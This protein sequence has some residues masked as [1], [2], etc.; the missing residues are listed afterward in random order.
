MNLGVAL[1]LAATTG[2]PAAD[3]A[4][5]SAMNADG[6]SA[7][8]VTPAD[9]SL[10]P[11]TVSRE[12]FDATGA[13]ATIEETLYTTKRVRQAYPNQ[14]SLTTDT[15]A[16]S[17]YIYSTDTI[18][19]VTNSS[20]EA[21]PKPIA[22]W[23]M[24]HRI[25]V[26]NS[27]TVSLT[28]FHRNGSAG[29]PVAAVVFRATDG[30]T[31]VT[32]TASALT[33]T[34]DPL[35]GNRILE[36]VATLDLTTLTNTAAITVN[37]RVYPRIG[38]AASVIDSADLSNDWDFSP[39]T[40]IKNTA[41]AA[42]PNLIYVKATGTDT[43]G[44]GGAYVGTDPDLAAASPAL[45]LT[46][47]INQARNRLGTGSGSLNGLRV[48]LDAGTW[49]RSATPTA[50]TV[51][52]EI[53]V[54]PI[55]GVAKASCILEFG[56]ANNAWGATYCRVRGLTLKRMGAFYLQ[57]VA[58]TNQVVEDCTLDWNGNTGQMGA[59]TTSTYF[60]NVAMNA[61]VSSSGL[62]QTSGVVWSMI[63]GCTGGLANSTADI[64]MI[65]FIGNAMT[66]GRIGNAANRAQDNR[67]IAFNRFIGI[68]NATSVIVNLTVGTSLTGF[69]LVQNV[70]EYTSASSQR[71][72]M[73]SGDGDTLSTVHVV[74]QHNTFAGFNDC[75]RGNLLYDETVGT[76]RTHK[77]QS[78]VGNIQVQI[79]TKSDIFL[80]DGTHTGNWAYD[81]GVGC[82]G[83]FSI[84]RNAAGNLTSGF[85]QTYP[86]VDAKIGTINTGAGQDPLFTSN[87][88]TTAG[89][90]A[91]SGGGDYT[92][93]ALSPA[94]SMVAD[95]PLAYDLAGNARAGAVAAGA[96]V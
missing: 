4:P 72:F 57:S 8:M 3:P 91:G 30:T 77:L 13:A 89:P 12:G 14:T 45:T 75:G 54:E 46:G 96:Y 48:R 23:S 21:S 50:N 84:Y 28:A 65:N 93:G 61:G 33:A 53:V 69:A 6:W 44:A 41:L 49:S 35:T 27:L 25:I 9:L 80:T 82:R 16:L 90:V 52:A 74:C 19:G 62:G 10:S 47:A 42:A 95:S 31:T 83:E 40:F 88:A 22:N 26:G 66:G 43:L 81:N 34:V 68:G 2:A 79:N 59:A 71:S 58:G 15:V 11:I 87:Q 5:I 1:S 29:K 63:R 86:G 85:N 64:E 94:K 76:L 78:F 70:F 38:A 32:A 20:A 7:T 55:P 92:I 56:A 51:T 39:R 17:D 73:P 37:A 60:I 36:Y 24:P 67:T 18:A